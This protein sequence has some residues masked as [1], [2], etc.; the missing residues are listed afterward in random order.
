MTRIKN[1]NNK[2]DNPEFLRELIQKKLLGYL[3]QEVAL[4]YKRTS[5]CCSHRN[6]YK[7]RQLNTCLCWEVAVIDP[8]D[9]G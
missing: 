8:A 1:T 7:P 4:H 6:G 5:D 3:E 9:Q 2:S